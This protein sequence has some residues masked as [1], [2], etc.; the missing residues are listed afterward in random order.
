LPEV[1][2]ADYSLNHGKKDDPAGISIEAARAAT[3]G[4]KSQAFGKGIQG[5]TAASW[6]RGQGEAMDR[7]RSA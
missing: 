2:G 6:T 4:E 5:S 3:R 7:G 1:I